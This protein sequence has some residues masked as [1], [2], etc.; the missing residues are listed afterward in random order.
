M[1]LV[2]GPDC[3]AVTCSGF[4]KRRFQAWSLTDSVTG[5]AGLCP[6]MCVPE[7]MM[8]PLPLLFVCMRLGTARTLS[9]FYF[10]TCHVVIFGHNRFD[11]LIK[12]VSYLLGTFCMKTGFAFSQ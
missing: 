5:C 2:R 7:L 8:S 10:K 1:P 12:A 6:G 9:S 11:E 3:T 4:E